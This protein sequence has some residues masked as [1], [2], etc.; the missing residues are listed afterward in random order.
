MGHLK[1]VLA[2][3]EEQ[4]ACATDVLIAKGQAVECPRH[5]YLIRRYDARRHPKTLR[6]AKAGCFAS[7]AGDEAAELLAA[8][9]EG[10][11]ERCPGC[12][13]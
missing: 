11:F 1:S 6:R 13:R 7:L 12:E 8:A 5:G 10:M 4:L 3:R 2:A 9:L